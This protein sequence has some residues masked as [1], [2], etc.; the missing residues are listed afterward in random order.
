MGAQIRDGGIE[1]QR[2][3]IGAEYLWGGVEV[4]EKQGSGR[5]VGMESPGGPWGALGPW[6]PWAA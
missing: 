5:W 2:D 4:K 6:G 1:G 3:R